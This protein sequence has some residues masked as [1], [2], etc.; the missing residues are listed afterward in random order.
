MS[1][2]CSGVPGRAGE[3]QLPLGLWSAPKKTDSPWPCCESCRSHSAVEWHAV[4]A[5]TV[6]LCLGLGGGWGMGEKG[7]RSLPLLFA[8]TILVQV[9][10]G[11]RHS[12]PQSPSPK[13]NPCMFSYCPPPR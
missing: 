7:Q 2:K 9:K 6:A 11:G 4:N 8:V 12:R 13:G 10:D 1:R 5:G 3:D